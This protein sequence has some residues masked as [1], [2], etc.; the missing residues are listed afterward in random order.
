MYDVDP[1]YL[2]P[3]TTLGF[4]VNNKLRIST[5]LINLKTK[6]DSYNKI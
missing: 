5:Y 4:N 1:Y 6:H 3:Y 2:Y